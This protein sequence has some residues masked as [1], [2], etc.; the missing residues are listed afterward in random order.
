MKSRLFLTLL[1]FSL[2]ACTVLNPSNSV[3]DIPSEP[4]D[5]SISSVLESLSSDDSTLSSFSAE[6][7]SSLESQSSID[8]NP[9]VQLD[10]YNFNDFHG[11]IENIDDL[12]E[13]GIAQLSTYLLNQ[14]SLNPDGFV[15]TSSGDMWQGSALS[16]MYKGAAVNEWM[17]YLNF[18]CMT[19]GNHEFDWGIDVI[20]NNMKDLNFPVISTNI[21]ERR[22]NNAV[23]WIYPTA[24]QVVN[25]VKI[26]F[27][28]AI[29]EGQTSDIL[30]SI[31]Y[32]LTFPDPTSY[33]KEASR[34]LRDD[35]ADIIVLLFHDEA[36]NLTANM[37]SNVDLV[38]CGH[39]HRK[40][41]K[42]VYSIPT[43]QSSN[44]GKGISHI[45]LNFN[46]NTKTITYRTSESVDM[47]Y[48]TLS[49][50]PDTVEIINKYLTPEVDAKLNNVLGSFSYTYSQNDLTELVT[51]YMYQYYIDNY[52]E[53]EIYATNYNKARTAL[54]AGNITYK[55]V[56]KAFPFDNNLV[57]MKLKGDVLADVNYG[58]FYIPR[59][60]TLID[61]KDYYIFTIDYI[62]E[63]DVYYASSMGV[64]IVAR[65]Q[66]VLPRDVFATYFAQ[67]F[68]N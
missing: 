8:E 46:K 28:G 63:Y 53:Y 19:L 24:T 55:D 16:N 30:A 35:G 26:G 4:S 2:T 20:Q 58:V 41:V 29:G 68:G 50:D 7:F 13:P 33:V 11:A 15:L 45:S 9:I 39:T 65:Y 47:R 10:F 61:D 40:E 67:E 1:A 52:N 36:A 23:D 56:F 22:S 66:D 6:S 57:V 14:K 37:V 17:N 64:E 34:K 32:N 51:R 31:S 44:N 59:E 3:S 62:A 48:K 12:G 42:K 38:F 49:D 21:F 43:V 27:V 60:E 54:P 5:E 25:G 18:S